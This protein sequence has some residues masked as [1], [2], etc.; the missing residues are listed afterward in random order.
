MKSISPSLRESNPS[1][2]L[3]N[4]DGLSCRTAADVSDHR[5]SGGKFAGVARSCTASCQLV[6]PGGCQVRAPTAPPPGGDAGADQGETA[7]AKKGDDDVID[8]DFTK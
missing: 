5:N 1:G 2:S 8:A 7:G 4:A 3:A 6:Q